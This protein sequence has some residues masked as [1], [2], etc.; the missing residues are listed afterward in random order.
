MQPNFGHKVYV[1]EIQ[2]VDI[3]SAPDTENSV[4]QNQAEFM[5]KLQ[6]R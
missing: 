1:K 2:E 5:G 6:Q 3:P 4:T